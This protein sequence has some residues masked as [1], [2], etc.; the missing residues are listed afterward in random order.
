MAK[1]GVTV[2][3]ESMDIAPIVW[4]FET[5]SRRLP[6]FQPIF[7]EILADF[8]KELEKQFAMEGGHLS[9]KWDS[10]SKSYG[11]WKEKYYPGTTILV[12]TGRMQYLSTDPT[13]N[14]HFTK[15]EMIK[16][17]PTYYTMYHQ[18]GTSK[19]V[20]RPLVQFIP[21]DIQKKWRNMINVWIRN[22]WEKS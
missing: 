18:T 15:S 3:I 21:S 17:V 5:L 7:R 13:K 16:Y 9:G 19:M 8:C 4:K 12:A 6:D 22:L 11:A 14:V 20:A 2:S 10:L 1:Y